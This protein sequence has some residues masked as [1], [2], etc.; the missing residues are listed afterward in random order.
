LSAFC[1]L[2]VAREA[3][4]ATSVASLPGPP[5]VNGPTRKLSTKAPGYFQNHTAFSGVSFLRPRDG[6]T[7]CILH[8]TSPARQLR[9][10]Q[11]MRLFND[12]GSVGLVLRAS[13]EVQPA[14]LF[15]PGSAPMRGGV[16]DDQYAL[17]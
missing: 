13:D 12:R 5:T 4:T 6:Q 11:R 8:P 15:V 17:L 14:N 3:A 9:S 10:G 7:Y 2:S 16:E 1:H